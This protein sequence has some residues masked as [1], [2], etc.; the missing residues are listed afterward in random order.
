MNNILATNIRL[1]NL[2][3]SAIIHA[4]AQKVRQNRLELNLTQK[5]L[6]TRAGISFGSLRRFETTG[7]ISLK[8]LILIAIALDATDE[9]DTLFTKKK[10][11][12]IDQLLNAKQS[13]TKKR[14]RK[15][16]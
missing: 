8:S 5:A 4:I 6:A 3:S 16:E 9:F 10:Y 15:T 14:G 11:Q 1:D 7:E 12:S 2:N 13:M